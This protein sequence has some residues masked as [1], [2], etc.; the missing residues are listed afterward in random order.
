MD[1]TED[2][3]VK[4]NCFGMKHY[5]SSSQ[6]GGSDDDSAS[7][8]Q[9]PI[10]FGCY[11]PTGNGLVKP[12]PVPMA[13]PL[14]VLDESSD[15]RMSV[16]KYQIIHNECE[17][18]EEGS[19]SEEVLVEIA[20]VAD[21]NELSD[22]LEG[23]QID[24]SDSD[25]DSRK[26][27]CDEDADE[28]HDSDEEDVS[29][30]SEFSFSSDA[31]DESSDAGAD[32]DEGSFFSEYVDEERVVF[33]EGA[34]FLLV[35]GDNTDEESVSADEIQNL[36]EKPESSDMCFSENEVEAIEESDEKEM[37]DDDYYVMQCLIDPDQKT[38]NAGSQPLKRG[39][40]TQQTIHVSPADDSSQSKRSCRRA[41]LKIQ[42]HTD[43]ITPSLPV[44]CLGQRDESSPIHFAK[45]SQDSSQVS[46]CTQE[47]VADNQRAEELVDDTSKALAKERDP[48]PFLTPPS[49]PNETRRSTGQIAFCE[50]PSNLTVDNALTA[51]IELRPLS[52]SS[53]AKLEEQDTSSNDLYTPPTY[54]HQR[55][56]SVSEISSTGLTP[57]LGG[58]VI[59]RI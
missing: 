51:A 40:S 33:E 5:E 22:D 11:K 53:L 2:E 37:N 56:R 39:L 8:V 20:S 31:D 36:I 47:E 7:G 23:D 6:D 45:R 19:D 57:K 25:S 1:E 58:I 34:G 35:S 12:T 38:Q 10:K 9:F 17:F 55:V 3:E 15:Q 54:Q 43:C 48:V 21:H 29:S 27:V 59:P 14:K 50:W 46:V 16:K 52:P 28:N 13:N 32:I 24:Y 4:R 49:T 42:E 30:Q 18:S 41:S 26:E 44:L